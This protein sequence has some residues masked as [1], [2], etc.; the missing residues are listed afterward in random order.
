MKQRPNELTEQRQ[1]LRGTALRTCTVAQC[2]LARRPRLH[3]EGT[4]WAGWMLDVEVLC[5]C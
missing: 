2:H 3:R 1:F 4:S 5:G